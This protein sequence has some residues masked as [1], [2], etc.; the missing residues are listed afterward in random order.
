MLLRQGHGGV[1]DGWVI[2]HIY[3]EN[4]KCLVDFDLRLE[5]TTLLLGANGAGKTAVLDVVYGLRKLLA[6]EVKITDPTA[7]PPTT[8]T[9]WQTHRHQQFRLQAQVGDEVFSYGLRIEHDTTGVSYVAREE[10]LGE[11]G[12]VLFQCEKGEV[13]LFR[14]DGSQGPSY[15]TDWSESALARVI[16][17][18][19]NARLTSFLNAFRSTVICT[20]NPYDIR[21]ESSK[22]GR[23]LDRYASN[24]V[25]WYRH[26]V[27]ENPRLARAHVEA[28]Q[29]AIV[30][31]DDLHLTQSGLDTRSLMLRFLTDYEGDSQS[32]GYYW[33]RF[34]E[35]SEGQQ[36]LIIL[37]G[38]LHLSHGGWGVW[39]WI[40][41]PDNY[42][43]LR[44]I[45]PWLMAVVEMCEDT[46]SQAIICSH[47]PEAIDYLG[48]TQG[49]ILER[50]AS[51]ASSARG[52]DPGSAGSTLRLSELLARGWDT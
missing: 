51:G 45:L 31:F 48:H 7:F 42:V 37:Y 24:F 9:R 17:H 13:Q 32:G 4:Y 34:D 14:D 27:Q 36:A 49:Q 29:S 30:G 43:S 1:Y 21:A 18:P 47:H 15:R 46:P 44:E 5:S 22:E 52:V 50:N 11:S 41:E 10:L 2:N 26:A 33:L 35:L 6:G 20:V 40:D 25:D 28:L 19:T 12:M 16:P 39:L 3:V 23:F 8:L 38:L